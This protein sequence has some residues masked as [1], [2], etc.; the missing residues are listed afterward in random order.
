MTAATT[1]GEYRTVREALAAALADVLGREVFAKA[2]FGWTNPWATLLGVPGESYGTQLL[3]IE[4]KP[5]AWIARFSDSFLDVVDANGD[6]VSIED[7]LATPERIGAIYHESTGDPELSH[8]GTFA[9]GGVGIREFALGNLQMVA[10]WSLATPEI[11]ERLEQDIA[12][13]QR[14]EA[15]L[16]CLDVTDQASWLEQLHCEWDVQYGGVRGGSLSNYDR[17]LGLPSELYFPSPENLDALVA[18]LEA[19]RPSG[20]PLDVEP[21]E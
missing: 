6:S 2:R 18:A 12:E 7:A 15:E 5:E 17:S 1:A 3:R 20:E 13:L 21:D 10:R 11:A 19:S 8:C 4:L 16:A 9:R 14:F